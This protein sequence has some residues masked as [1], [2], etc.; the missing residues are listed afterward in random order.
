MNLS[1][2]LEEFR[3]HFEGCRKNFKTISNELKSFLYQYSDL[4]TRISEN[5]RIIDT[6]LTSIKNT[7][8]SIYF[9]FSTKTYIYILVD[10]N[11]EK[12]HDFVYDRSMEDIS[13]NFFGQC[14]VKLY[15]YIYC[16]VYIRYFHIYM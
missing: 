14:F 11:I 6:F 10:Y 4:E 7:R 16:F 1:Q 5:N 8:I 12:L 9:Y 13:K 15:I 3:R 2:K